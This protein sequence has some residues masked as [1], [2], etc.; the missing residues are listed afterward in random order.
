[1][2]PQYIKMP[3]L[4][5]ADLTIQEACILTPELL[6]HAPAAPFAHIGFE[7]HEALSKLTHIFE[8]TADPNPVHDTI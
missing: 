5:T 4:S 2:V 3:H 6:N 8:D 1:M 7:K